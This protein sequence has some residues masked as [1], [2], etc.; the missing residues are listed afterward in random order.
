MNLKIEEFL[1]N[2]RKEK[3]KR[4]KYKASID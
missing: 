1:G 4:Y 2:L 3:M